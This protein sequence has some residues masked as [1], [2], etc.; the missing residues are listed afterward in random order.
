MNS[1]PDQPIVV[2]LI[3]Y[4]ATGKSTVAPELAKRLGWA[5]AD[6]DQEVEAKAGRTIT[7]IFSEDG[8]AEFRRIERE[9]ISGLLKQHKLVLSS[10]GGAI[11]DVD[12]RGDIASAGPV[13]W[14][15]ASVET[16]LE[17]LTTDAETTKQQRPSLTDHADQRAE[18][19]EVLNRRTKLYADAATIVI[20]TD[21]LD[22]DS[23]IEVVYKEVTQALGC[24][25]D[26]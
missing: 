12:T 15:Q 25:D 17:R 16:I 20:N 23:V 1:V 6:S 26:S 13:V 3:G 24:G 14:L 7:Q 8:E 10:G 22:G 5:V 2:T 18:I 11:L 9:V 21:E 4:R 19:T